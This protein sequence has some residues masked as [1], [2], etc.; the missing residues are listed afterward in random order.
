MGA[1]LELSVRRVPAKSD[2]LIFKKVCNNKLEIA[3]LIYSADSTNFPCIILMHSLK[4][5]PFYHV[6]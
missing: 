2:L 6:N 1:V 3:S 5:S 4:T